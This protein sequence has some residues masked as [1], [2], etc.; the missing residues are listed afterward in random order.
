MV[1]IKKE[2]NMY[3]L[4]QRLTAIFLIALI[5]AT[6]FIPKKSLSIPPFVSGSFFASALNSMFARGIGGL[7]SNIASSLV[8]KPAD[9]SYKDRTLYANIKDKKI[10]ITV[11]PNILREA[12]HLVQQTK[13]RSF[14]VSQDQL[15]GNDGILYTD[16]DLKNTEIGQVFLR[17]DSEFASMVWGNEKLQPKDSESKQP[18]YVASQLLK[19]RNSPYNR[20]LKNWALPPLSWPQITLSFNPNPDAVSGLV[21]LEYKPQ[22]TF[23]SPYGHPVEATSK[24]Q[25][26][27][28][29]P[30]EQLIQDVKAR[31]D[32]YRKVLPLVNQAASITATMGLVATACSEVESCKH[33]QQQSWMSNLQPKKLINYSR[34]RDFLGIMSETKSMELLKYQWLERSLE[35]F[36]SENNPWDAP[37]N[38]VLQGIQHKNVA[39]SIEKTREMLTALDRN[40]IG[41]KGDIDIFLSQKHDELNREIE[42]SAFSV[43][44]KAHKLA[45][46]HFKNYQKVPKES[47]I[48]QAALAVVDAWNGEL[49]VAEEDLKNA[50]QYSSHRPREA[51]EAIK[52]GHAVASIMQ[53]NN[54]EEFKM[55]GKWIDFRMNYLQRKALRESYN[56]A[57]N[58]LRSCETNKPEQLGCSHDKLLLN[59]E[60]YT[61]RAG[62]FEEDVKGKDIPWLYGRFAYLIGVKLLNDNNKQPGK[63][64]DRLR[65]LSSYAN[66]ANSWHS[67][68]LHRLE[69]D[70]RRRLQET[71]S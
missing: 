37:Y 56:L 42:K 8:L 21:D 9:L 6:V 4:R 38:A 34:P 71:V 59:W 3:S 2:L 5:F 10:P 22:V 55:K 44:N 16:E 15:A 62:L 61:M 32:E 12:I 57:D 69:N 30:Y 26:L 1:P 41:N 51:S 20:L 43:A 53:S 29:I 70:L 14:Q 24:D 52:L 54:Q 35:T 39:E 63:A 18:N 17:A 19:D 33:L 40:E 58:Y 11:S 65:F 25:K 28:E 31:P 7:E 66:R 46:E 36:E 13:K 27:G 50:I 67:W 48:L 47:S 23:L 68:K 60:A 64:K 45:A 49:Y